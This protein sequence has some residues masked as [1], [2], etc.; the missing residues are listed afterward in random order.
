MH[1]T[2]QAVSGAP[3]GVELEAEP[4]GR[5]Q[6]G[7]PLQSLDRGEVSGYSEMELSDFKD[8]GDRY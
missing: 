4:V 5:E 2:G 7:D 1:V 6:W 8:D 3:V